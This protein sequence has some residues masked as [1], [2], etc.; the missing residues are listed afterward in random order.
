MGLHDFITHDPETEYVCISCTTRHAH[1]R[2]VRVP[3]NYYERP[4]E[5][6]RDALEAASVHHL[7]KSIVLENTRAHPSG[8]WP[9]GPSAAGC[10]QRIQGGHLLL[11][12]SITLPAYPSVC[13]P[14][15]LLPACLPV[16]ARLPVC[17]SPVQ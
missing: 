5:W 14:A 3:G 8:A 4:L 13:L 15:C 17:L 2:F 1:R 11:Q 12:L 9:C 6:R 10:Q 7:C 16:P